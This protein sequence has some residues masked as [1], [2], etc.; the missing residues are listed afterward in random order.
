MEQKLLIKLAKGCSHPVL[1]VSPDVIFPQKTKTQD[2]K[3]A[4]ANYILKQCHSTG[5]DLLELS[6]LQNT[7]LILDQD[8]LEQHD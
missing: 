7:P 1:Q 8:A 2:K 3:T 5:Y 4:T 6:I